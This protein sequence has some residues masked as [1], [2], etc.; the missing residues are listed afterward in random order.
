MIQRAS[1]AILG[2]RNQEQSYRRMAELLSRIMGRYPDAMFDN[3]KAVTS[4]AN[5]YC[6]HVYIEREPTGL[7]MAHP[8][9]YTD[10]GDPVFGESIAV[11]DAK[12][13]G[14]ADNGCWK[15]IMRDR[16]YSDP[17]IDAVDGYLKVQRFPK[18]TQP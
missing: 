7:V 3:V 6:N 1:D 2:L 12:P 18:E 14:D 13:G 8:Y 11:G 10:D 15:A 17:I 9:L 4:A 16:G 5:P